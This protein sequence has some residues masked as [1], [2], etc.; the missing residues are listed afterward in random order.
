MKKIQ[1]KYLS[2]ITGGSPER[3]F[4]INTQEVSKKEFM[5]TLKQAKLKKC[6]SFVSKSS[7]PGCEDSVLY[8]LVFSGRFM[9][10]GRAVPLFG[11][12]FDWPTESFSVNENLGKLFASD[13]FAE[14]S[15][16]E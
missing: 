7:Y 15:T 14:N 12:D 5:M 13:V 11:M 4:F 1:N 16:G 9:L 10:S 2:Y 6:K 3:Q 8:N